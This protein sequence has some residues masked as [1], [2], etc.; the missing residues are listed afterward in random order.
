MDQNQI[1]ILQIQTLIIQN[2][3]KNHSL[4]NSKMDVFKFQ[5]WQHFTVQQDLN[6]SL[7]PLQQPQQLWPSRI[8]IKMR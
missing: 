6:S 4:N 7:L 5:A 3:K 2:Q 1:L 8:V